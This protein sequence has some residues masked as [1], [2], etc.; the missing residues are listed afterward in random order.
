MLPNADVGYRLYSISSA[1]I[2]Y[3]L[4]GSAHYNIY[5]V[6]TEFGI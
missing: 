3:I 4:H 2:Q 6:G 1:Y 5:D